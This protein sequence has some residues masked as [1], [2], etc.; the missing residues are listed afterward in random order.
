VTTPHTIW[1]KFNRLVFMET[2][3]HSWHSVSPVVDG[4]ARC[5]VSNYYFT[6]ASPEAEHYYHVTSYSARPEQRAR[7][8][9]AKVDNGL[10]QFARQ[11]LGMT[12]AA[13]RGYEAGKQ[14]AGD[15]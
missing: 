6:E 5:C 1:S 9:L 3:R 13:D 8:M 15:N 4:E 10:R 2:N 7:R 11:Q 12:R 14:A